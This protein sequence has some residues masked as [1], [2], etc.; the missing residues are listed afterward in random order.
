MVLWF[1]QVNN[2]DKPLNT[3]SITTSR[4][5]Q[6]IEAHWSKL[7]QDRKDWFFSRHG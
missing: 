6:R 1:P 5:N 2:A 4:V 7:R 3:F